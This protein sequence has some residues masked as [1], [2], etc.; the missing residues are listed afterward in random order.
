MTRDIALTLGI[1]FGALLLFLWNKVR[2]DVAGL[3]VMVALILVG[4]VTPREG[5][6][7]FANEALITVAAMFVLSAGLVRTG[8]I[9]IIGK[10][11][12]RLAGKSEFRLL[13]VSL[14]IVIPTSAFINNTPV[15]VVMIPMVLGI[16]RASGIAPS[17]VFMP[18]S[19]GSQLGG[20]LTLIGTS[21]NLLVA[22]LV[23]ELGLDRINLFDITKP[24]AVMMLIGVAYLLT[25]GRWL[26]PI[27]KT[28]TDLLTSY[29][30][31]D[32]LSVLEVGYDSPLVGKSLIESRFA[33]EY[34]LQVVGIEREGKRLPFIHGG[35]TI[36]M[37]DYLLV[38]GKVEKLARI[39]EVA[40]LKIASPKQEFVLD[41][42]DEGGDKDKPASAR[43]LAEVIIPPGS[44]VT[45]RSLRQLHFRG[46]YGVPVLGIQ[47]HGEPLQER[48]RDVLLR[49]GDVLLVQG[50][51]EELNAIHHEGELALLGAVEVPSR[52]RKKL[53]YAIG[54]LASVVLLAAFNILPILVGGLLGVIAMFLT[55][56]VTPEEAYEEVDWMVLVLL[57][58]ILPLGLA[59][60]KTGTA[61]F[62]ATSMLRATEPLGLFGTLAVFYLVTSLLTELISN[63]AAAVVLTPIAIATGIALDVSPLPFVFAVML[64]ASNSFMTPIGYQT[65]TF[66]YGPGGYRFSDF[67][68]VGAPLNL[69]MLVAAT[70]VIPYFFPF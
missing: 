50:T 4:L 54:I 12:Q 37:G 19:F 30:L 18:I 68:R 62:I 13:V 24:A 55:G 10:W 25:I 20:T 56:C 22:G 45:G 67:L 52:R 14:A 58:A 46:R 64:A 63:N 9:D 8:A 17:R 2:V 43:R 3:I 7:G 57:G 29:E 27:R 66:I 49:P 21:T 53:K 65:N 6:S 42:K 61:E 35:T 69:L 1:T 51:A 23:L 39:E 59:M 47:R 15:V 38:R 44:P 32:Y 16:A 33:T 41:E 31:R 28:A 26:T 40:H 5:I 70:F 11:V 60:Q 48:M 36:A 34:G